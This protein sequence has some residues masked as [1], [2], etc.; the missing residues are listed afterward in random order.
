MYQPPKQRLVDTPNAVTVPQGVHVFPYPVEHEDDGLS[1]LALVVV[2]DNGDSLTSL[3]WHGD[4]VVTGPV[5]PPGG[6]EYLF[7]IDIAA[8]VAPG[9]TARAV[10]NVV[11]FD[12]D[13]GPCPRGYGGIALVM[14]GAASIMRVAAVTSIIQDVRTPRALPGDPPAVGG[15]NVASAR[16]PDTRE[17]YDPSLNAISDGVWVLDLA[18]YTL[19]QSS[20]LI[21][22]IGGLRADPPA[23]WTNRKFLGDMDPLPST[24]DWDELLTLTG[25]ADLWGDERPLLVLPAFR[26]DGRVVNLSLVANA[27]IDGV[28]ILPG[29]FHEFECA[30]KPFIVTAPAAGCRVE[31]YPEN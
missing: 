21:P 9:F 3:K 30:R 6:G 31:W 14:A 2:D 16:E 25:V 29:E 5:A 13:T 8:A 15:H 12:R 26:A 27:Y 4:D 22:C 23:D 17:G 11:F 10:N 1:T 20:G 18:A 28:T 7:A 19:H 24:L